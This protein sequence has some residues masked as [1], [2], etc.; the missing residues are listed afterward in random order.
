M[1]K[2]VQGYANFHGRPQFA[3]IGFAFGEATCTN[4]RRR[5]RLAAVSSST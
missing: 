4:E 2:K 3:L 5:R 1:T